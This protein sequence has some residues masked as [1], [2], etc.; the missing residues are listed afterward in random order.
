M[1]PEASGEALLL[2][3]ADYES[4]LI[5]RARFE[6]GDAVE[7]RNRIRERGWAIRNEISGVRLK[8]CGVI[9]LFAVE[10]PD[11]AIIQFYSAAK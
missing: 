4:G 10:T 9:D 5:R 8:P 6:V 2:G 7:A 3:P 11:G 1:P